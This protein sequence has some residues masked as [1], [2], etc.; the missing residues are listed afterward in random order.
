MLNCVLETISFLI[1]VFIRNHLTDILYLFV[2]SVG[3]PI[4]Y[5]MGI[6]EN[7]KIAKQVFK[8]RMRIFEK[9]TKVKIIHINK[10][11]KMLNKYILMYIAFN[12]VKASLFLVTY[13]FVF[14][15]IFC[16]RSKGW[17]QIEKKNCVTLL[18]PL[19]VYLPTPFGVQKANFFMFF[20]C[21]K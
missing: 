4:V 9:K 12:L 18:Q 16:H 19:S 5:F 2:V 21:F 6:E 15:T 14:Y 20:A 17:F 10:W 13:N 3:S 11:T 1:V 8:S 7:R